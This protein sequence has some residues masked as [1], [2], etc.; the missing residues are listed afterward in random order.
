MRVIV[1]IASLTRG[2]TTPRD[3]TPTV[4]NP[5]PSTQDQDEKASLLAVAGVLSAKRSAG[6]LPAMNDPVVRR[7]YGIIVGLEFGRSTSPML[8]LPCGPND[9]L[10]VR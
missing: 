4:I 9:S 6:R 2:F 10:V 7:R 5:C 3:G 1:V 8:P